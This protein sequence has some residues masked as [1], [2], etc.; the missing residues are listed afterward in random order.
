MKES[1]HQAVTQVKTETLGSWVGWVFQFDYLVRDCS[2]TG[3]QT[4]PLY[5]P[6]KP[7]LLLQRYNYVILAQT[8][9]VGPPELKSSGGSTSGQVHRG[10]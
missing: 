9:T 4:R 5:L 3:D 8:V 10:D 1:Q 2:H 7:L 6:P